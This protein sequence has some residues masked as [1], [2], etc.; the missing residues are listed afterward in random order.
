MDVEQLRDFCLSLDGSEEAPHF[1]KIAWKR[2]GKIIATLQP[3]NPE[4]CIKLEPDQQLELGEQYPLHSR[5]VPNKWGEKGWTL[6]NYQ[7]LP[8][9]VLKEW[10]RLAWQGKEK[11]K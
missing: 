10:I 11:T 5:P 8:D 2:K 7:K 6:L 3:E 4:V 1:E 9:T